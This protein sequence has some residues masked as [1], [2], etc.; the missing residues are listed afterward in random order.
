MLCF[1]PAD[2]DPSTLLGLEMTWFIL[3]A[4]SSLLVVSACIVGVSICICRRNAAIASNQN[5]FQCKY[6]VQNRIADNED[7]PRNINPTVRTSAETNGSSKHLHG[8][9]P[10]EHTTLPLTSG[11]WHHPAGP[12]GYHRIQHKLKMATKVRPIWCLANSDN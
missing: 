8:T 4:V 12:S 5:A 6:M 3:I 10:R 1:Y 2:Q 11:N 9:L 7:N